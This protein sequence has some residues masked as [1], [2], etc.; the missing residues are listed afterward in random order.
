MSLCP[1][2]YIIII[3]S[4]KFLKV[5]YAD[6]CLH[7]KA[8]CVFEM[9]WYANTSVQSIITK[10]ISRPKGYINNNGK[11]K[12]GYCITSN[13]CGCKILWFYYYKHVVPYLFWLHPPFLTNVL[14]INFASFTIYLY[15]HPGIV[16]IIKLCSLSAQNLRNCLPLEKC[17]SSRV[18]CV[19]K[20]NE[21]SV[22]YSN[23]NSQSLGM[24]C[25]CVIE[26]HKS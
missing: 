6:I 1:M 25:H 10:L 20:S 21:G 15:G 9:S 12:I 18:M 8:I 23:D 24:E 19:L 16:P 3:A 2:I 7:E 17:V 4:T 14:L 11:C 5:C 26:Y 22:P 13:F